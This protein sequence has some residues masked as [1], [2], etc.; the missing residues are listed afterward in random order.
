MALKTK[1]NKRKK[2]NIIF[3]ITLDQDETSVIFPLTVGRAW[4]HQQ[5][6]ELSHFR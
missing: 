6:L 2:N 3:K 5:G 1:Q 4:I